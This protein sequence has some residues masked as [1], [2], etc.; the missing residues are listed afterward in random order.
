[1]CQS[2]RQGAPG[3]ALRSL[4]PD[5]GLVRRR[6]PL[7]Q[8]FG[9]LPGAA[10]AWCLWCQVSSAA[11][12]GA[13]LSLTRRA[14]LIGVTRRDH[15]FGAPRIAHRQARASTSRCSRQRASVGEAGPWLGSSPTSSLPAL[16][17][18]AWC[19][20]RLESVVSSAAAA[21]AAPSLTRRAHAAATRRRSFSGFSPQC[22]P[23]WLPG[24]RT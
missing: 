22:L 23:D 14:L 17:R 19:R 7:C 13:A 12:A 8:P 24:Q 9:G 5:L 20:W 11:A 15:W 21:V 16:R 4:R 10:G 2:V 6:L 3:N 18:A 1:M